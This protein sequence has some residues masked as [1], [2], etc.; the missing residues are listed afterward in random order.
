MTRAYLHSG[1]SLQPSSHHC[2]SAT[3]RLSFCKFGGIRWANAAAPSGP[4]QEPVKSSP[5][6]H[7]TILRSFRRAGYEEVRCLQTPLQ[8]LP[9]RK[10][11][12]QRST[13][14]NILLPALDRR[15]HRSASD[16]MK[17]ASRQASAKQRAQPVQK[18]EGHASDCV[19]LAAQNSNAL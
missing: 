1:V 15:I 8:L 7:L 11:C 16:G 9:V 12:L 4:M 10:T 14:S 18:H 2:I 3:S 19:R 13:S 6:G 17:D 5:V